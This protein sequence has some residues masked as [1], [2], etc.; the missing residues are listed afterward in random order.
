MAGWTNEVEQLA[1][2]HVDEL[3]GVVVEPVLQGAGGMH[4][5]DPECLRVLRRVCDDRGLL[6]VVDEIATGFGRTGTMFGCEHAGVSPDV[7]CLGKAL[8][9]GYL[10]L[11]AV[12]TT[13][14]VARD[15]S[16][17]ESGVL[18]HGPTYM[19]NPLACAVACAS[20]SAVTAARLAW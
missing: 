5:Y 13:P 19:G 9:G 2:S 12:L 8:S 20:A 10:T 18:M 11:S 17:S 14:G 6:L 15:I 7:M 4:V 16:A 1:A 3:A